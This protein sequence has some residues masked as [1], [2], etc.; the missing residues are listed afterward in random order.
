MEVE[1][2]ARKILVAYQAR[3][4][5]GKPRKR[6]T[7]QMNELCRRIMLEPVDDA[8]SGQRPTCVNTRVSPSHPLQ[9][10]LPGQCGYVV[11]D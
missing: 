5:R 3:R 2:M 4:S 11:F 7:D 9:L 8:V 1:Q 6:W 10:D